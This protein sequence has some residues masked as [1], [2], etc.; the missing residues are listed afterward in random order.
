ME[1]ADVVA[2]ESGTTEFWDPDWGN[3]SNEITALHERKDIAEPEGQK[4]KIGWFRVFF[5][6]SGTRE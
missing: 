1:Y 5:R 3:F 2:A 6:R 4:W